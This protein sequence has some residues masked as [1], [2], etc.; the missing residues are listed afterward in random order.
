[1]FADSN[2]DGRAYLDEDWQRRAKLEPLVE[3]MQH[4]GNSECAFGLGTTD[5]ECGF[6]HIFPSCKPGQVTGCARDGAF[7][8]NALKR[9]LQLETE[10]G[11]NPYK[12]GFIGS[13]DTHNSIPGATDESTFLGHHANN[14]DTAEK[15]L[16]G[17]P[18][19]ERPNLL[20]ESRA[21]SPACGPRPTRAATSG[22]RSIARRRSRPAA[23]ASRCGSSAASASRRTSPPSDAEPRAGVR[24]GRADGRRSEGRAAAVERLRAS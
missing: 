18:R 4:K 2:D 17:G 9:G 14:D 15:R 7:V 19:P 1:M 11:L 12:L 23:R 10:I 21:V 13:T 3:I 24:A 16:R 8:R 20:H 5:E 6:E 22:T